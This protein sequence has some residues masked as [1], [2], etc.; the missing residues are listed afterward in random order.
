MRLRKAP[1]QVTRRPRSSNLTS[2]GIREAFGTWR[3]V[4]LATAPDA[5]HRRGC[6]PVFFEHA[7]IPGPGSVTEVTEEAKS[8]S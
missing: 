2:S 8:A 7:T 4:N 6:P 3:A 1:R 5:G